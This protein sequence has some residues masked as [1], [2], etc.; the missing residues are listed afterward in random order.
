[1]EKSYIQ[2]FSKKNAGDFHGDV[3]P[4]GPSKPLK[5]ITNKKNK[6]LYLLGSG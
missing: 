4:M 5:K 3:H 1:M 2:I 6:Q